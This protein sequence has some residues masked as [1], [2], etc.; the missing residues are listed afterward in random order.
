MK[1]PSGIPWKISASPLDRS[2]RSLYS[3]QRSTNRPLK[4]IDNWSTRRWHPNADGY[5]TC[6]SSAFSLLCHLLRY[7]LCSCGQQRMRNG[8]DSD[9]DVRRRHLSRVPRGVI[10]SLEVAL[11]FDLCFEFVHLRFYRIP[12]FWNN[13]SEIIR[14]I[15]KR[16][17]NGKY[18]QY[19]SELE[20]N[21]CINAATH[22]PC[23]TYR[24]TCLMTTW[25][26]ICN[27]VYMTGCARAN[28]LWQMFPNPS[29]VA[30]LFRHAWSRVISLRN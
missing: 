22:S 20:W 24:I 11:C 18:S 5:S 27:K 29:S 14:L 30:S 1:D 26:F 12:Q 15:K 16:K 6:H 23:I 10:G 25:Q 8:R 9:G 7:P 21:V 3:K 28:T 19:S 13:R 17:R 2:R 4:S